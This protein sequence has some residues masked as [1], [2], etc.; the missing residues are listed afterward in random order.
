MSPA[1]EVA[2]YAVAR[3]VTYINHTFTSNL[4]LS[5]SLQP[6]AGVEDD[7]IC[8]FPADPKP[9]AL[10]L[11]SNPIAMDSQGRIRAPEAPG[12]G[13]E[14]DL[15]ALKKYLVETEIRVGGRI[16]YETPRID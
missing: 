14:V 1:K 8:E 11:A 4:A 7:T 3:G 9:L 15:P 12:L 2:D 6:F 16:V 13:I 10:A 5:A